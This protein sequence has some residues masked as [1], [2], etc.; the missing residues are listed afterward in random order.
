[1]FYE[2]VILRHL[3]LESCLVAYFFQVNVDEV[4]HKL[5]HPV[6][7]RLTAVILMSYWC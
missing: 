3:H 5:G 1:M 7:A 2:L 4:H 6:T